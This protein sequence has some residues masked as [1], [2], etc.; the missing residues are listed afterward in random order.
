MPSYLVFAVCFC[1]RVLVY[2]CFQGVCV[3]VF[4][5]A[6]SIT[7]QITLATLLLS[8]PIAFHRF[9][10]VGHMAGSFTTIFR[11][12]ELCSGILFLTTKKQRTCHGMK[13]PPSSGSRLS[14]LLL[15]RLGV[16]TTLFLALCMGIV[17]SALEGLGQKNLPIPKGLGY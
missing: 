11:Q 3:C 8:R 5:L 6:S 9:V 1:V 17:G 13:T 14:T 16:W 2:I 7:R 10:R 4:T 12:T 15:P